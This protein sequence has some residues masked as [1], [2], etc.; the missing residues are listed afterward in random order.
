MDGVWWILLLLLGVVGLLFWG[1]GLYRRMLQEDLP[2]HMAGMV[3]LWEDTTELELELAALEQVLYWT[4]G[5]WMKT[6]FL[7]DC[8]EMGAWRKRCLCF[9]QSHPRFRYCKASELSELV[10]IFGNLQK[11]KK[12]HCNLSKKKV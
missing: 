10:E 7:V 2:P 8:T 1:Y 12:N 4:E 6:I 5:D 3:L 9:C 11:S